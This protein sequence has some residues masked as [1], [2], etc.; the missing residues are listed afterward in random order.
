[1]NKFLGAVAALALAAPLAAH[2]ADL[3]VKAPYIAPVYVGWSG[4]YLGGNAGVDWSR[5][6]F[7]WTGVTESATAFAPGAATVI[8]AA[9]NARLTSTGFTGGGQVGCNYQ[10]GFLVFGVEGDINYTGLN[11]SRTAVSL[12]N[13][14]G[15]PATIVPG[16][17]TES[18]SS[19]WLS[20]IRGRLGF[21]SGHWLFYGTGGLAIANVSFADQICFPTAAV[22]ICN[23]AASSTTRLGWAAGGGIE[24]MFAPGW[25]AKAEY[26]HADLGSVSYASLAT[27][28]GTG[29]TPFPGATIQHGHNLTE[30]LVR[31]GVNWHFG[32]GPIVA[33]Y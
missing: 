33:R 9:A 4:C 29:A 17:I 15:G 3:P 30:D 1:M 21:A 12:G 31:V 11:G 23:T 19:H 14:N 24:W 32:G 20:T 2:A 13:T 8:P 10:T 16:N 7:N 18:F 22:P 28:I 26:L 25:S 27:G 5:S 6:N